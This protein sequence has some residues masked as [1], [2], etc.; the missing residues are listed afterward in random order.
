M[1]SPELFKVGQSVIKHPVQP[2]HVTKDNS[3]TFDFMDDETFA[4]IY[5]LNVIFFLKVCLCRKVFKAGFK[6]LVIYFCTFIFIHTVN[7]NRNLTP[8]SIKA[9]KAYMRPNVSK[10]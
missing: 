4:R 6:S 5:D 10:L 3:K 9:K 1:S 8:K 2:K 7:W